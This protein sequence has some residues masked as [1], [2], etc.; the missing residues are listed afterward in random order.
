MVGFC[1][2]VF[3]RDPSGEAMAAVGLVFALVPRR[4]PEAGG[5]LGDSTRI[6]EQVSASVRGTISPFPSFLHTPGATAAG[7][8]ARPR[9]PNGPDTIMWQGNPA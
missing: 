5:L 7:R 8:P 6:V 4:A 1:S 9:G 2:G 3:E